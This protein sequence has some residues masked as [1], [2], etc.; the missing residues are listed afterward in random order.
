VAGSGVNRYL[1]GI[2]CATHARLPDRP[3]A[4][5]ALSR[6]QCHSSSVTGDGWT[7]DELV[8]QVSKTLAEQ[9]VQAPS[10]RVTAV[11]DRRL[12]RWY[13]TIGLLDRPLPT[14]GRVARYGERHLLQLVAVKRRQAEGRSLAEIQVELAGAPDS[15]LRRAAGLPEVQSPPE[16]PDGRQRGAFWRTTASAGPVSASPELRQPIGP[17]VHAVYPVPLHPAATLVL[18]AAPT[19]D[20]LAAIGT[21]ARPLLDLLAGRGLLLDQLPPRRQS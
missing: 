19:P 9:G 17:P 16:P 3:A 2:K 1:V 5:F 13:A 20:D 14:R 6:L 15:V 18:H 12:I 11:P 21:A 7:I 10:G 8:Q 4:G